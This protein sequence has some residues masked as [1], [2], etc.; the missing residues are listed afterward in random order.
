MLMGVPGLSRAGWE[1]WSSGSPSG[2]GLAPLD[3]RDPA[4]LAHLR[5]RPDLTAGRWALSE[6][7]HAAMDL[8][9]GLARDGQR[10]AVASGV[11]LVVD[12]DRL[13]PLPE[14]VELDVEGR[15][16]GGEEHELLALVPTRSREAFE[17]RGFTTVGVAHVPAG[18]PTIRWERSGR[19]FALEPR[20][21]EHF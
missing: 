3:T 19:P 4:L 1:R 13:P 11:D 18:D 2:W 15:L 6:G 12:V 9:D 5:P 14:A 16:A 7:A 17:A 8:S 20:P 10:L 21:F